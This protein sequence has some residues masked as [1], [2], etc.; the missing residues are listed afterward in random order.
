MLERYDPEQFSDELVIDEWSAMEGAR[1]VALEIE[2]AMDLLLTE[3]VTQYPRAAARIMLLRS[4][5]RSGALSSIIDE[6]LSL[7]R[8]I[9]SI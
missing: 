5:L 6:F 2:S 7:I 4:R 8:E 1:D 3:A 9:D